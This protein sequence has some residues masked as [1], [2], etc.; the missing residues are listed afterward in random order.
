MK[1][2]MA[3]IFLLAG[4]TLALA[5]TAPTGEQ[6]F[7]KCRSCHQT[8]PGAKN[9]IGPSLNRLFGRKAGTAE[10]YNY[11]TANRAADY[12]WTEET[13]KTFIQNPRGAMPGT[14]MAFPGLKSEAEIKA[15]T[16]YLKAN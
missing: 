8:G 7:A 9:S 15:L 3:G 6:V 12:V 16:E 4:I 13:F 1:G 14:K 11:S 10:G 5:Q 2:P